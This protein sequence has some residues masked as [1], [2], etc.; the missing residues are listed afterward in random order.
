MTLC[1]DMSPASILWL[2]G[3]CRR[4]ETRPG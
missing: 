2:A 1:F 3:N 4:N